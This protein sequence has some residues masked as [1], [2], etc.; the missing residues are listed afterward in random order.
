M[1]ALV[2]VIPGDPKGKGRPR[3]V[4]TPRGGRTYTDAQTASYE[5]L[6]K[7]CAQQA[8]AVVTDAPLCVDIVAYFRP[9]P[10]WP[11]KRIAAALANET[12]PGRVDVD[13]IAKAALDGLNGV[14]FRDDKQVADLRIRKRF[15]SEARLEI[16]ISPA[17]A[18]TRQSDGNQRDKAA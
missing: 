7:L 17:M 3:F 9:S 2:I 18:T 11:K 10:S 14:A 15:A 6:V 4:S 12:A 13:N 8:G 16:T 1:G 5:N